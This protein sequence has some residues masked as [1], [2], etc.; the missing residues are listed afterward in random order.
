MT[1]ES[2]RELLARVHER[3]SA[4]GSVDRE[5]RQLLGTVMRDIERTLAPGAQTAPNPATLAPAAA[6]VPRLESL[7]VQFEAGHPGL[8]EL[9]RRLI[10]ALG[11][12]GI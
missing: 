12:A 4:S 2:L 6:H 9:L 8:A 1:Q 10:D 11:K 7:A 3:L 5:L